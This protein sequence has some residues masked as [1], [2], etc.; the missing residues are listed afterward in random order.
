MKCLCVNKE[1][2]YAFILDYSWT[3]DFNDICK[4]PYSYTSAYATDWCGK[5]KIK[6][7]LRKR[8]LQHTKDMK[9]FKLS[10]PIIINGS[11]DDCGHI[12]SWSSAGNWLYKVEERK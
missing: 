5:D 7:T 4:K 3:D 11:D 1:E 10:K 6:E 9:E 12:Y 8:N 2:G